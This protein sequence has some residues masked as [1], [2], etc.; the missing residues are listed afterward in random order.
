MQG[1]ATN[2]FELNPLMHYDPEWSDKLSEP[3]STYKILYVYAIFGRCRLNGWTF[4]FG[5]PNQ[6]NI[7]FR[8]FLRTLNA[9]TNQ[10]SNQYKETN[11]LVTETSIEKLRSRN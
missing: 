6:K 11:T 2:L 5:F 9:I 4:I 10:N 7:N 8:I 3:G 1:V